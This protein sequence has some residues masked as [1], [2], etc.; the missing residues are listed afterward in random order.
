VDNIPFDYVAYVDRHHYNNLQINPQS[1]IITMDKNE[2]REPYERFDETRWCFTHDYILRWLKGKC[3][4]VILIGCADFENQEHYNTP[5]KFRPCEQNVNQSI[6]FIENEVTKW[7][8]I[9]KANPKGVLK[10][11]IWSEQLQ[12]L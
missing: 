6:Q 4:E 8:T 7:Y 10:L 2:V 1:T 5:E 12:S 11:P 3:K 9:Y